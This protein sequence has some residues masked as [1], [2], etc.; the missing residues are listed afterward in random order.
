MVSCPVCRGSG[1]KHL[2]V[3]DREAVVRCDCFQK[4]R[5]ERLIEAAA[6]PPRY[7]A[8][9]FENFNPITEKLA[10]V[11]A[12]ALRYVEDYPTVDCGLLIFGPCGVG[13][14]HLAVSIL[15]ELI[16]RHYAKGLFSDFR[17]LLKKIQNSYNPISHT[18]EMQILDPVLASEVLVLDDLGAERPT[19]WV[20]DTFAYIINSRYN[21]KLTTLIT[22]NFEDGQGE[23]TKLSDG[24]RIAGEETLT[25]RIGARLRSRLYEMCKVIRIEGSDFRVDV[26]QARHQF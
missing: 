15:R 13:K 6:V 11:K 5:V 20:R 22:T 23:R 21:Q 7:E 19:E 25:D 16:Q 1:W 4:S 18:S 17:D 14:T 3:E 24:T 2:L 12:A 8:C 26:K 10:L 9:S